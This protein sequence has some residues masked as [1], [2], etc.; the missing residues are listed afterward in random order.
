VG[1]FGALLLAHLLGDFPC[2]PYPLIRWKIASLRG[3][4]VH[5]AIQVALTLPV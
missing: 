5:V 2:Q 4:A 1:V 3:L